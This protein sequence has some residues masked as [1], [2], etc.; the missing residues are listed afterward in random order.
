MTLNFTIYFLAS[1]YYNK[2]LHRFFLSTE[3]ATLKDILKKDYIQI[4]A[5]YEK[6]FFL[7]LGF[8]L[9]HFI[10]NDKKAYFWTADSFQHN[11]FHL[12][13][14]S[15]YLFNKHCTEN[16]FM[17]SKAINISKQKEVWL[18]KKRFISFPSWLELQI[19]FHLC[20]F[21]SHVERIHTIAKWADT[22]FHLWKGNVLLNCRSSWGSWIYCKQSK[23][24]K[25][26]SHRLSVLWH[27]RLDRWE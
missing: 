14:S 6:E 25:G 11:T 23:L 1:H 7:A 26:H 20:M 19:L 24:L 18:K 16:N 27:A 13:N 5:I 2:T 22:W 21:W 17:H 10:F 15:Q 3:K 12:Q 9:T 8:H 4:G